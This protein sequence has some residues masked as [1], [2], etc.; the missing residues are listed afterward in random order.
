MHWQADGGIQFA[1][2]I[3]FTL[4]AFIFIS[5]IYPKRE[6]GRLYKCG[7][8]EKLAL[9]VSGSGGSHLVISDDLALPSEAE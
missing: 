9:I 7:N 4:V 1:V 8:V 2:T 6:E 3:R 5:G